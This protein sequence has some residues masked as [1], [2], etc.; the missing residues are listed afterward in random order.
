[1]RDFNMT[2]LA[3]TDYIKLDEKARA[4]V[5]FELEQS[6]K[7]YKLQAG[8]C[9]LQMGKILKSIR[10]GN[11]YKELGYE[12]IIDWFSS[13]DVSV[14]PS[15]AWA[16][17][18]IYETFVLEYG[19]S[20]EEIASIDYT[21]LKDITTLIKENPN[22]ADKWLDNAKNLRRIDL[23]KEIR[24][25]RLQER[26]AK[27]LQAEKET[28]D[29][30]KSKIKILTGDVFDELA[31]LEDES[32]DLVL[33]S[34][35]YVISKK[36]EDFRQHSDDFKIV[37]DYDDVFSFHTAW[38]TSIKRILKANGS[39]FIM[40]TLSNIFTIGHVLQEY[41]FT[42]IRDIIWKKPNP[43][44]NHN[45]FSLVKSHETILW[46][47]KGNTHTNNLVEVEP[48]VW[49]ISES[50]LYNYHTEKPYPLLDQLISM[51]TLPTDVILDPFMGD[52]STAVASYKLNR[53][54]IGIE[55][56]QNWLQ[57]AKSRLKH[58]K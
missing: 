58:L 55:S 22:D 16:F 49:E 53:S 18:S 3:L 31:L 50:S 35:P 1:M 43:S 46:A 32:V 51:G 27:L 30:V 29:A 33:T 7:Q 2:N 26:D 34:P 47:R 5:A 12:S 6:F 4:D 8:N 37:E 10:D 15:W 57:I 52:G 54:Y 9:F 40:G 17:I 36:E 14:T 42:L 25:H 11:L 44:L 56:D 21:K 41:D 39:V 45:I 20:E 48:D 24:L 13:P 19:Y 28:T 38:I 23:R